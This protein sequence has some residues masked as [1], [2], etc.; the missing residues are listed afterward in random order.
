M[1]DADPGLLRETVDGTSD[2]PG[3]AWILHVVHRP[4]ATEPRVIAVSET[5]L[6]LVRRQPT[7][8]AGVL[9][10][11]DPR[12]SEAK[13]RLFRLPDGGGMEVINTGARNPV[14]TDGRLVSSVG[15]L[16][17]NGVL[18]VGECVLVLE[19]GD[20]V[21]PRARTARDELCVKLGLGDSTA[22]FVFAA[23]LRDAETSATVV[24]LE[25]SHADE[26]AAV[27]QWFGHRSKAEVWRCDTSDPRAADELKGRSPDEL[28]AISVTAETPYEVASRIAETVDDRT[29]AGGRTLVCVS[30]DRRAP[31]PLHALVASADCVLSVPPLS[32]RRADVLPAFVEALHEQRSTL[33]LTAAAAERLALYGWPGG[34]AELRRAARS[35]I[36]ASRGA[37]SVGWEALPAAIRAI[38]IEAPASISRELTQ[39]S[40]AQA[41]AEF[42]FDV[43]MVAEHFGFKNR[44][45][46]YPAAKRRGL[47]IEQA[48][49]EAE[50][51]AR[52]AE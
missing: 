25:T 10:L 50:R 46:L 26:A 36:R 43:S 49:A 16:G 18:R 32:K 19:A 39:A 7:R 42:E 33:P 27:V 47:S 4:G 51:L 37:M 6:T 22:R 24:A 35:S 8:A 3:S 20:P 21:R 2:G 1:C 45:S 52:A 40:L 48:R 11:D 5:T 44:Q 31:A 30:P 34:M 41:F 17:P 28:V 15:R 29:A 14:R 9:W 23:D 13:T 38:Q 12:V